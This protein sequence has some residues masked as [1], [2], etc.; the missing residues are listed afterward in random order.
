MKLQVTE[1]HMSTNLYTYRIHIEYNACE[2]R[3]HSNRITS[4]TYTTH[5]QTPVNRDAKGEENKTKKEEICYVVS[6]YMFPSF[7][8]E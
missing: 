7:A 8:L 6:T 2:N 4:Q 3:V 1:Q 5:A